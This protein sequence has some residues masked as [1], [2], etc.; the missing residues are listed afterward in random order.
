MKRLKKFF[1][2]TVIGGLIVILPITILVKFFIW[3][4]EWLAQLIA[5]ITSI[6]FA[7]TQINVYLA[8]VLSFLIVLL[9]CFFVGITVKTAWG[10]WVHESLEYWFLSRLP[11]YKLLSELF[12]KL[13]PEG[14]QKFS[15]PVL[16]RLTTEQN[17]L[18][19]FIMDEYGNDR[20]AVFI[21]T[22][23]SPMNGFVVQVG[24]ENIRFVNVSVETMMK[25]VLACGVG[26]SNIVNQVRADAEPQ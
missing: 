17:E 8:Q 14:K 7:A 6:L 18:F 9:T 21:P 25:S 19:G 3:L 26:S 12:A 5:P 11:G 4:L 15:K 20:Y 1:I 10:K 24:M 16:V 2:T 23:P 22:S 13:K